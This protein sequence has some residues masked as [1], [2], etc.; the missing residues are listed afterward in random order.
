LPK[1]H[2]DEEVD[3][4]LL[5]E[6]KR[7]EP[8][9]SLDELCNTL[10]RGPDTLKASSERLRKQGYAI[11]LPQA[12]EAPQ[13][14]REPIPSSLTHTHDWFCEPIRFGVV[15]D[16]HLCSI[17][18]R[19]DYL[20]ELYDLFEHQGI[21]HVYHAGDVADG[22]GVYRGHAYE[23]RVL[24]VDPQC[25]YVIQNYPRRKGMRTHFILGN[26]D[27]IF[28]R[29]LGK[30]IGPQIAA[31]CLV[32]RKREGEI[33][34]TVVSERV[35]DDLDYLGDVEAD[36]LLGKNRAVRLRLYHPE[37]GWGLSEDYR[38]KKVIAGLVGG[39]KPHVMVFGHRHG[40]CA[41]ID[42]NVHWF[43]GGCTQG[44]S[45]F[46]R[47][48]GWAPAL[49]GRIVE[50]NVS[51]EGGVNRMKMEWFGFWWEQE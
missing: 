27:L 24:G 9:R 39:T 47:A 37:G 20:E 16:T 49:G 1:A 19:L 3:A 26:H 12:E 13:L 48:K 35:R 45:S 34:K 7:R 51:P 44:Q 11:R 8:P 30:N 28:L 25:N 5:K 18:E 14:V 6:L 21:E 50:I 46:F 17:H 41:N 38:P 33:I 36:V 10:D 22:E 40:S 29:R 4:L 15:S 2:T 31:G 23:L 32:E 43:I 42:R